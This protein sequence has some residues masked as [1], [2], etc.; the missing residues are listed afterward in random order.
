MAPMA[1]KRAS[2]KCVL[3]EN[4]ECQC[5]HRSL[6]C[7]CMCIFCVYCH[8]GSSSPEYIRSRG[9]TGVIWP[10]ERNSELGTAP[11]GLLDIVLSSLVGVAMFASRFA[12]HHLA[13]MWA[14][15]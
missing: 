12:C 3:L 1:P 9:D 7:F 5:S 10:R 6:T 2:R 8:F 11:Q 13:M 14:R 4:E 15:E